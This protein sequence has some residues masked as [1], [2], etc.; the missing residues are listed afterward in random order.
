MNVAQF[1]AD[2]SSYGGT[3]RVT[4]NL[5]RLFPTIGVDVKIVFHL[6]RQYELPF[7]E[8]DPGIHFVQ[9]NPND[10][11]TIE[12]INQQCRKYRIT[13]II[14][15]GYHELFFVPS[16]SN[17]ELIEPKI[18]LVTQFS[19]QNFVKINPKYPISRHPIYNTKKYV[20]FKLRKQKTYLQI[21]R[22]LLMIGEIACISQ[23]CTSELRNLLRTDVGLLHNIHCIYNPVLIE[24]LSETRDEKQNHIVYA[25]RL[26][27]KKKNSLLVIKAW[28]HVFQSHPDWSL[29]ILG[30]GEV[31]DEI[32]EYI[33]YRHINNVTLHGV[34]KDVFEYFKRSKI[35]VSSSNSDAL[36]Q[37]LVEAAF[38]GNVLVSSRFDGGVDEIVEDAYNGFIVP[39]NSHKEMA[40]K[41]DEIMRSPSLLAKLKA[42]NPLVLGK[43]NN[44]TVLSNWESLFKAERT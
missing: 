35:A 22:R 2:Y 28:E 6:R 43:F 14:F 44:T 40:R 12:M 32:Q 17:F 39:K 30:D 19:S 8:Y 4:S 26:R 38:L 15:Q 9:L 34:K 24:S 33:Q 36:P 23:Q 41:L 13:H 11:N 18:V 37:S 10:S 31:K 5:S 42:N 7:Y 1:V 29:H 27:E 16:L 20:E 21:L 3:E 25:G